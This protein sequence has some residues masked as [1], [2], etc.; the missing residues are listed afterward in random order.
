[1]IVPGVSFR[2]SYCR[3][4]QRFLQVFYFTGY[5]RSSFWEFVE[6][7]LDLEETL[8]ISRGKIPRGYSQ[9]TPQTEL[10]EGSPKGSSPGISSDI[11]PRFFFRKSF[12]DLPVE[13]SQKSVK[14]T[15][16]SK[17]FS[18]DLSR[19]FTRF[20]S[21]FFK[22]SCKKYNKDFYKYNFTMYFTMYKKKSFKN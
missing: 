18:A 1:M 13:S 5:C 3:L 19:N 14:L 6:K 7:S 10:L 2:D 11:S 9:E 16:F 22:D 20:S 12:K 4:F 17:H 21:I 8:G 15:R